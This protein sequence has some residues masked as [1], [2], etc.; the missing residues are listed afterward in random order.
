MSLTSQTLVSRAGVTKRTHLPF[1]SMIN[2]DQING[3]NGVILDDKADAGSLIT[4][5]RVFSIAGVTRA[6]LDHANSV[7]NRN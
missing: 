3:K 1:A 7:Q 2:R 4:K 6:K 5:N